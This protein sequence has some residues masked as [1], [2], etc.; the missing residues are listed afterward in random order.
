[1]AFQLRNDPSYWYID[2]VSVY[3]KGVQMLVNGGFESGSVSPGWTVTLPYGVCGAAGSVTSNI[4]HTG[5]YSF[6]DGSVGCADQLSQSFAV[7]AGQV[8]VVSFWIEMGGSG[9]AISVSVTLS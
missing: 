2:D 9:S 4:P 7:I 3:T 1:L 6:M 8:Y 5:S